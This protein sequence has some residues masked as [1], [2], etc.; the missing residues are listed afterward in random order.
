M[1]RL[2]KTIHGVALTGIDLLPPVDFNSAPV[3]IQIPRSLNANYA[4]LSYTAPEATIR[5][6]NTPL[7]ADQSLPSDAELKELLSVTDDFRVASMLLR[8]GKARQAASLLAAAVPHKKVSFMLNMFQSGPPAAASLEVA[9]LATIAAFLHSRGEECADEPVCLI[10][11]G[12]TM[13]TFAFLRGSTVLLVGKQSFG[14]RVLRD[15]ICQDLEV[16]NE[17]AMSI[18]RDRSISISSSLASVL[19]PFI[20]QISISKDFVERH[21]KCLI[22]KIYISGGLSLLPNW[23]HEIGDRLNS[24]VLRWSPLENIQTN[25]VQLSEEISAQATRFT[26]AI[27]AALGGL[28]K[29]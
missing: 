4:C 14:C 2:K 27:G 12:E 6:I 18:L 1:V 16:D 26:A 29:S 19:L 5:V 3:P 22:R 10:D 13:S 9:G 17:L 8:S 23:D 15:K 28:N 7:R 24:S 20:K 21:E 25:H 11:T